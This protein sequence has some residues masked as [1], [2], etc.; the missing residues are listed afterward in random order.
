MSLMNLKP[1]KVKKT[2]PNVKIG[3]DLE[4]KVCD[5][6][7]GYGF[8][9]TNIKNG[10]EGQ[11]CDIIACHGL[12]VLMLDCKHLEKGTR[13]DFKNIRDNQYTCFSNAYARNNIKE[14]GF[15]IACEENQKLYYLPFTLVKKIQEIGMVSSIHVD[16]LPLFNVK[17]GER[18][19]L[20]E[21]YDRFENNNK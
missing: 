1:K 17:M 21:Y 13:F 3:T 16:Q 6:L 20:Y 4:K 2:T 9:S 12:L 11:P 5:I 10:I 19:E 14:T 8:W 7:T 18:R 15:V